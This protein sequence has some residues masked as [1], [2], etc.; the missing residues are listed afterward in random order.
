MLYLTF[1]HQVNVGQYLS[2]TLPEP[3][4]YATAPGVPL[5]IIIPVVVG[6]LL[7]VVVISL[8]IICCLVSHYRKRLSTTEQEWI[9]MMSQSGKTILQG[10]YAL[11]CCDCVCV[12]VC[13]KLLCTLTIMHVEYYVDT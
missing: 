8:F 9:V 3:L 4:T 7:I 10:T 13:I 5:E 12:R 11:Q 2:E 6:G 1:F